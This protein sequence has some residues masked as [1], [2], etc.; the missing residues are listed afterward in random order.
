MKHDAGS[1][2]EPATQ[3]DAPEQQPAAE[4]TPTGE[5]RVDEAVR[6]LAELDDLPVS[7]HPRVYE[8]V[9]VQLVDVLGELHPGQ[10]EREQT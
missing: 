5:P 6:Q 3:A 7:E 8:R 2:A 1:G 10:T 9:H 4:M